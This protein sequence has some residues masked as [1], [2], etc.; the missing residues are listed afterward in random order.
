[1]EIPALQ[2]TKTQIFFLKPHN[3]LENRNFTAVI[4]LKYLHATSKVIS[5]SSDKDIKLNIRNKIGKRSS[6]EDAIIVGSAIEL[7]LCN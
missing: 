1:M 3:F 4:K 5:D 7:L 6:F 2:Q